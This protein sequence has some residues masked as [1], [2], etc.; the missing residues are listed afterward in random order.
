VASGAHSTV[1]TEDI[2]L[3][4]CADSGGHSRGRTEGPSL[5]KR[6]TGCRARLSLVEPLVSETIGM[7]GSDPDGQSAPLRGSRPGAL[8]GLPGKAV[9]VEAATRRV[10]LHLAFEVDAGS[11]AVTCKNP[12]TAAIWSDMPIR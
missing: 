10:S 6:R 3:L 11:P 8:D 2:S 4:G 7:I 1:L 12:D 5:V 9:C